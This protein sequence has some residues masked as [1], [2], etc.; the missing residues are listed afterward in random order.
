MSQDPQFPVDIGQGASSRR[1]LWVEI[2]GPLALITLLSILANAALFSVLAFELELQRRTD[3]AL[4]AARTLRGQM[5]S[6]PDSRRWR[7]IAKA[8]RTGGMEISDLWVVKSDLS[9]AFVLE[10]GPPTEADPGLEAALQ[11][12]KERVEVVGTAFDDRRVVV[13][14]EPIISGRTV[15]AL[16]IGLP[17]EGEGPV[18][19]GIGLV[20]GF[21][22]FSS[23]IVA[24]SGYALLR[25]RL[26]SPVARLQSATQAIAG[27]EFET[28]VRVDAAREL[29]ELASA[30]NVLAVSLQSY[31]ARTREQVES[32]EAANQEL[33]SVQRQ[34]IRS[35]QL[36]SVGRMAAGIAHEVGN[37][38]AAVLGYVE[39]LSTGVDD[40][41]V[42]R[43]LLERSKKEI[44]RINRI[45]R[46]LLD[47]ARPGTGERSQVHPKTALS[48][49]LETVVHQPGFRDVEV[50]VEAAESLPSIECEADKFHQVLVNLLLN[51][52]DAIDGEG[53]VHA[54][55]KVV[56]VDLVIAIA[57]DGPGFDAAFLDAIF[58]PFVT[59]KVAGRGTGLGLAICQ[60][61]LEAEGGWIRAE[62][63]DNGGAVI[64]FGLPLERS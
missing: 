8:F 3:L 55:A 16:R 59:T 49:A 4:S 17:L 31:R 42:E 14:T 61:I 62:N 7:D 15:S 64:S 21:T 30:L 18:A 38:L 10:G 19:P 56:D 11:E 58:E 63:R 52:A 23:T 26:L 13:V 46:D 54:S 35:A 57:D 9:P 39:V 45:V 50:V 60:S 2:A 24:L 53:R 27:G 33:Q 1:G 12:K 37:P 40:Q 47:F 41:E 51:A 22:F 34:L 25:R 6:T 28:V 44:N 20:L 29:S 5:E 36:A 32:L 48:E 43:D